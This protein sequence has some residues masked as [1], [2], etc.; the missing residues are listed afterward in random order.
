MP[1]AG[2]LLQRQLEISHVSSI[3]EEQKINIVESQRKTA[4]TYG[5]VVSLLALSV[6][7]FAFINVRQLRQ[8]RKAGRLTFA[9]NR[10]L[11]ERNGALRQL[12]SGLEEAN[13][14]KEGYIGFY[15]HNSSQYIDKMETLKKRLDALLAAKQY[16]GAQKLA[17]S[18][19]I[20]GTSETSCSRGSTRC[21][22]G[23]FP[24]SPRSSTRCLPKMNAFNYPKTSCLIPGC[25]S[26]RSSAW[27][28]PTASKSAGCWATPSTR[29]TPTR[30]G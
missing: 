18:I 8:L 26:S 10:E 4:K 20:S 3:I 21:F 27:A 15:F 2:P 6:I 12:N 29:F 24:T 7:G 19:H 28:L 22:C 9:T 16:A 23:S 13:R 11:Q 25:A 30:R 1:G 5:I 17:E 14:I